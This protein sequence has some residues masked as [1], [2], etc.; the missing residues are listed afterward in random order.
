[1][2]RRIEEVAQRRHSILLYFRMSV[3][4]TFRPHG[5]IAIVV[6]FGGTADIAQNGENDVPDPF[7]HFARTIC[8][9][10]QSSDRRTNQP[11]VAAMAGPGNPLGGRFI[12]L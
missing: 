4:S 5:K 2:I 9:G 8:C 6:A 3:V 11:E 7:R 1:M 12:A 10:A